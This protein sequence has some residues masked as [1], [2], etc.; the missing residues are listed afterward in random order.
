M[1]DSPNVAVVR[2]FY[3]NIGS[4]EMIPMDDPRNMTAKI[5]NDAPGADK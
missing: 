5:V 2:K 3:D 1:A 4:P